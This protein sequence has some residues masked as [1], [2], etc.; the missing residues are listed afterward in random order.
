VSAKEAGEGADSGCGLY[1]LQLPNGKL[2]TGVGRGG[3]GVVFLPYFQEPDVSESGDRFRV[4]GI[5][6]THIYLARTRD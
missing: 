5:Y 2:V 6:P 4:V 1:E 3:A